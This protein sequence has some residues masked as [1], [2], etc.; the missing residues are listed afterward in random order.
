[1]LKRD[2]IRLEPGARVQ[3]IG[4]GGGGWG[5]PSERD[6]EAVRR[7]VMLGYVTAPA[8]AGA[9]GVDVDPSADFANPDEM[10]Q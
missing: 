5:D 2:G 7:D 9:Y 8:A 4:G 1:V 6:Q 10:T 3:L